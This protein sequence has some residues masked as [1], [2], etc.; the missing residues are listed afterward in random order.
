MQK[1]ADQRARVLRKLGKAYLYLS[2][3]LLCLMT[4]VAVLFNVISMSIL[5]GAV[6]IPI[7]A[8]LYLLSRWQRARVL[9]V[10]R[11]GLEARGEVVSVDKDPGGW[12]VAYR[13]SGQGWTQKGLGTLWKGEEPALEPGARVLVLYRQ[14]DPARNVLWT[15]V[16]APLVP[17]R[18]DAAAGDPIT[19][20]V[21]LSCGPIPPEVRLRFGVDLDSD[22]ADSGDEEDASQ[23][24][25]GRRVKRP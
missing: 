12:R 9:E 13:F 11:D 20:E 2:T 22:A 10:Y 15:G 17:L 16:G 18:I 6:F 24:P 5:Q 23:T 1:Y 4:S 21:S 8:V 14:D 7:G 25:T 3:V 19:Q